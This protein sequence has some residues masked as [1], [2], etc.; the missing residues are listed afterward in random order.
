[1][2]F[3]LLK[4]ATYAGLIQAAAAAVPVGVEIKKCTVDRNIALTF[5]DGPWDYTEYLLDVLKVRGGEEQQL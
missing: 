5:D 3:S 4:L 1:M 2:Q